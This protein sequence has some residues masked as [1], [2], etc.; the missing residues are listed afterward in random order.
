MI[1]PHGTSV[2]AMADR[3]VRSGASSA[4]QPGKLYGMLAE[5]AT[6]A[7]ITEAAKRVRE[8]GYKWWDCHVPFAVHGLDKAMGVRPTI[9]PV[10]VFFGGATGTL[11]ALAM[12]ILTNATNVNIPKLF[13]VGYDFLISGKPP[14]ALPAFIPIA[15]ELT[16]LLSALG[17]VGW[18][19]LLNG[20][21][22]LYHPLF[23]NKRFA[24]ATD[25]R[26]FIVI[27]ARDPKFSRPRTEEFLR[28]LGPT[29]VEAMEA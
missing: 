4:A 18:V 20:L 8:A 13:L 3:D 21:P 9:L 1:T 22:R 11:I 16:V 19:L 12:Q 28:S 27:E 6:P 26:F 25:D 23:K 2:A 29:A 5:F 7:A 15:F 14:I 24:R 17:C 10:L